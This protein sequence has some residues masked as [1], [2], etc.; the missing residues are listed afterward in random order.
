MMR[1]PAGASVTCATVLLSASLVFSAEQS[2]PGPSAK[3]AE[4]R[5]TSKLTGDNW[6]KMK[7]CAAQAEK[8]IAEINRRRVSAGLHGVGDWI[9]RYS[10]KYNRCFLKIQSLFESTAPPIKGAPFYY[11][12]L[13]DAFEQAPVAGSTSGLESPQEAC[14]NEADQKE[15]ER[16]AEY[17][18]NCNIEGEKSDC[19]KATQFIDKHMKN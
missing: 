7:D 5:Q 4:Q 17:A 3:S 16:R 6:E 8:A 1:K 12:S 10:P 2:S 13:I 15:C 9:D 18:W 19:S 11:T 14:R